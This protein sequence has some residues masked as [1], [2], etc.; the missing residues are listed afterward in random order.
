VT[1]GSLVLASRW[2][3]AP[4]LAI[5]VTFRLG[6]GVNLF[7][8]ALA[9]GFV[10]VALGAPVGLLVGAVVGHVRKG[11]VRTAPDAPPE[12]ARPYILGVALPL[13]YLAVAIPTYVWLS[14]KALE[15]LA[16]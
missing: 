3:W 8:A 11:R 12:G 5:Y 9:A 6:I 10:G 16:G 7:V 14:L 15:W 1:V 4:F 13:I 2:G